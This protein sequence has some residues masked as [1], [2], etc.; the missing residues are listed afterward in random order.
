MPKEHTFFE[1]LSYDDFRRLALDDSLSVYEKVGFPDAYRLEHEHNIYADLQRKAPALDAPGAA[2]LDIGCGCSDLPRMLMRTAEEKGQRL[3]LL[4]SAEMLGQLPT[5][6]GDSVVHVAARFPD[7][8]EFLEASRDRFDVVLTYS[9]MQYVFADGNV[10]R[11]LDEALRLLA[12]GGRLLIGDLPNTSMRKR[13]FA[14]EAGVAHHRAFTRSE[15]TPQVHF[16]RI[17]ADQI[18]DAVVL[19]L[20]ARARAAGFHAFVL[21]Q[22]PELPMANRRE[23]I[24]IVRP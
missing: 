7:C 23:D 5:G 14:S 10:F 19:A 6:H 8:P 2:I 4:D 21:P 17:E 9:V 1:N 22:P 24:L 18:D 20:V 11:F 13:F 16:N 12:P 3:F 15:A